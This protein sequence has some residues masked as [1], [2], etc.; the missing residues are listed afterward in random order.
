MGA[1]VR[2]H[3]WATVVIVTFVGWVIAADR[4]PGPAVKPAETSV[5]AVEAVAAA[6][7]QPVRK[8]AESENLD[9]VMDDLAARFK[10][11]RPHLS[12]SSQEVLDAYSKLVAEAK[13]H[14]AAARKQFGKTLDTAPDY[15]P[16]AMI[17]LRMTLASTLLSQ[18]PDG[19]T[20]VVRK[21]E[22]SATE[23][24][25]EMRWRVGAGDASATM[26]ET[27]VVVKAKDGWK[28][29]LPT[30]RIPFGIEML[31]DQKPA[32]KPPEV[33][34]AEKVRT[35][36]NETIQT[37]KAITAGVKRLTGE[38]EAGKYRDTKAYVRAVYSVAV[39]GK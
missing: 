39:E 19:K 34:D 20:E 27:L 36:N 35:S 23:V 6:S 21:T 22:K 13:A 24:V 26:N 25:V 37:L 8:P 30:R 10:A 29:L 1:S 14:D 16:A 7:Q 4:K 18:P 11:L 38:V 28:V 31:G 12:E 15:M 32:A 2:G 5:E 33:W 9:A 17:A 3:A